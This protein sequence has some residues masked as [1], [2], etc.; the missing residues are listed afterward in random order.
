[1]R[2][3]LQRCLRGQVTVGERIVGAIGKG[4]VLLVGVGKSDT[5]EDAQL[6]ATKIL[7]LR[8]FPEGEK[9]NHLS[10][11]EVEGEILVI[12]QF[13]LYGDVR[14][15]RRPSFDQAMSARE[16]RELYE[17]FVEKLRESGLR[18]ETGEFGAMMEVSLV[19][20]GPYTLWIES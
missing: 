18:I 7:D 11:R 13:T 3:L 20:W 2:V 10:I 6:L 17:F 15:G 14:K 19:N 16:A 9:E 5:K 12:S 4:Y 8:L 1:M